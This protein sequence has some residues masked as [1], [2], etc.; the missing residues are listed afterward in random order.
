MKVKARL[1]RVSYDDRGKPI[2]KFSMD[3]CYNAF[4]GLNGNF[5]VSDNRGNSTKFTKD[6]FHQLFKVIE[7]PDE[8]LT[9]A[10]VELVMSALS[11]NPIVTSSKFADKI[12]KI[13]KR[14]VNN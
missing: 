14:H 9:N 4:E 12:E 11:G 13:L 8:S 5:T 7:V 3:Q 6:E 2:V 10:D 1:S